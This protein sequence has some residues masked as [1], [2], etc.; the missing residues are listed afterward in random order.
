MEPNNQLI[1]EAKEKVREEAQKARERKSFESIAK[2]II[3]L[4]E[5]IN[6][7]HD[8]IKDPATRYALLVDKLCLSLDAGISIMKAQMSDLD[9]NPDVQIKIEDASDK[10]QKQLIGL[11]DWVLSPVY[12][13]D[14]AFGKH[15]MD[16]AKSDFSNN[17]N[18]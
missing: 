7:R 10:L 15:M 2:I 13:P 12:G 17:S 5:N 4:L 9:V 1:E 11:M 14:H 3:G 8:S 18:N 6:K 16:S